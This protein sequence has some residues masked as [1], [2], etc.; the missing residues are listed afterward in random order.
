MLGLGCKHEGKQ[1]C[2]LVAIRQLVDGIGVSI[3]IP[4]ILQYISMPDPA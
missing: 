4:K 1:E 2:V 3:E